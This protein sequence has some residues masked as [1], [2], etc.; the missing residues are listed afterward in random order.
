MLRKTICLASLFVCM[1]QPLPA[2]TH[3]P[4]NMPDLWVR[5]YQFAPTNDKAVRVQVANKG[6][7]ASTA[8]RLE[9][10]IRKI[11]GTPV[12]RTLFRVIQPIQPGQGDWVLVDAKSILPNNVSLNDTTFK[13]IADAKN[14][15]SESDETNNEKW[16]NLN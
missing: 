12:G 7:A 15:V 5:Q 11:N 16:H 6:N 14:Q 13:L 2:R 8:C 9:I 4:A 3:A 10:T 1:L